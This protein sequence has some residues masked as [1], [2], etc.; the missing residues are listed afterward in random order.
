MM[1]IND[2]TAPPNIVIDSNVHVPAG[3]R[4]VLPAS[5]EFIPKAALTFPRWTF[6]IVLANAVSKPHE[7]KFY[8]AKRIVVKDERS[9]LLG[10][11]ECQ[12][13]GAQGVDA[14]FS[15]DRISRA[16]ERGDCKRTSKPDVAIKIL[17]KW[18]T[19]P[20]V[21]EIA[22]VAYEKVA[23]DYMSRVSSITRA[24]RDNVHDVMKG[25]EKYVMDNIEEYWNKIHPN[26]TP[27]FTLEQ[28]KVAQQDMEIAGSMDAQKFLTVVIHD[29]KYIVRTSN[30]GHQ[31]MMH[32]DLSEHMRR[33]IGLLKL[34]EPSQFVGGAGFKG[35]DDVYFVS[36]PQA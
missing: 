12:A 2:G 14:Y 17:K 24:Y 32:E 3:E 1:Q 11:I 23:R 36:N 5:L 25:L 26:H 31:V 6:E 9:T 10:R 7:G 16:A 35:R 22:E 20:P 21:S 18:F 27:R 33:S 30:G 8:V 29:G 15:N 4:L 34:V 28:L 13:W 19:Q